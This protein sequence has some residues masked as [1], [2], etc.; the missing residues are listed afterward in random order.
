MFYRRRPDPVRA[1][2]AIA[3]RNLMIQYP[4]GDST[5]ALIT[6]T[7]Q[8]LSVHYGVARRGIRFEETRRDGFLIA[9][10]PELLSLHDGTGWN[11]IELLNLLEELP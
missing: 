3:S 1:F 2:L 8:V 7:N 4:A 9:E 11:L 5:H 6:G 10:Y